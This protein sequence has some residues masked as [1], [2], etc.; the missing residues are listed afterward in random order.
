[1]RRKF[2]WTENQVKK[3]NQVLQILCQLSQY[4]PL[5]LRQI[6]YQLVDKG[7]IANKVSEYTMLSILLKQARIEGY[8]SWDDIEDKVKTFHN[9]SLWNNTNKFINT[10]INNLL[11]GYCKDLMQNQE[12]YIEIWI[13]KDALV[14]IFTRV[15]KSFTIPVV[16]CKGFSSVSFLH[17]YRERLTYYQKRRHILLFFGDFDPSEME[18]L[19]A[20]E[21]T[22]HDEFN[23]TGVEFKRIALL[24]EDIQ[25]YQL[26]HKPEALKKTDLRIKKHI[27]Q[28]GE[29]AV[30]LDALNPAMLEQKLFDAIVGEIDITSFNKEKEIET[31]E[32]NMLNNLR[33]KLENSTKQYI[34]NQKMER[35]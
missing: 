19:K 12:V 28:F 30:E 7:Y 22:L 29:L 17:E 21:T 13:E 34:Y 3:L 26:P 11:E 27:E 2:I 20:I 35:H 5:T 10:G 31:N 18:M 15:A 4:Q 1:M 23:V 6:Y 32:L 16:V 24:R 14:S 8:I 9:L 33:I 25:K